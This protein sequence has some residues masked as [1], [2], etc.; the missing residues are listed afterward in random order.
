[1]PYHRKDDLPESVRKHLPPH[2]LDIY[3]KA[4]NSAWDEYSDPDSRRGD[5]SREAVAH[6][7][8]WAAVKQQYLKEG[9]RWVRRSG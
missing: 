7:V 8:A 6:K 9:D 2:A 4:F 3:L 5:E 1:M